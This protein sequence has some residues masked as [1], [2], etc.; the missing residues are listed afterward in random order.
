MRID[1][2][3]ERGMRALVCFFISSIMFRIGDTFGFAYH[4]SNL[5]WPGCFGKYW[6]CQ[7]HGQNLKVGEGF[8]TK[9]TIDN[10]G[11]ASRSGK[12]SEPTSQNNKIVRT[13]ERPLST[14][15]ASRLWEFC[16]IFNKS[17]APLHSWSC[18]CPGRA[19]KARLHSNYLRAFCVI[20]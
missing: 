5:I 15:I 20:I 14:M 9:R 13:H 10:D 11:G 12:L 8:S 1:H 4:E 16:L 17:F 19:S 6:Q 18:W 3:W 7:C 2:L